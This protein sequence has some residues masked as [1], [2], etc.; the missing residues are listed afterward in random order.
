MGGFALLALQDFPGQGTALV[1]VLD[2]FWNQKG[3]VTPDQFHRFCGPTVPLARLPRRVFTTAETLTADLEIAHFGPA[4]L[5]EATPQVALRDDQGRILWTTSLTS[6]PVPRGELTV[7]GHVEI[8]LVELPRPPDTAWHLALMAPRSRTTGT[9]GSIPRR[10]RSP[11]TVRKSSAPSRSTTP[12]SRSRPASE[13]SGRLLPARFETTPRSPSFSASPAFSGTPPGPTAR[14]PPP[15]ASC[16][17]PPTPAFSS[18][19]TDSHSN[20]QW[21]Y[22]IHQAA[23]LLLDDLPPDL[24][25]IVQ[26]IDDWFTNRRLALVVEAKLGA[27]RLLISSINL[28]EQ[29]DEDPVIRQFR[30]SLLDYAASDRFNPAALSPPSSF[31]AWSNLAP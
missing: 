7:L 16:A 1:G 6:L 22:L 4:D 11:K 8:P 30:A 12:C 25:A 2:P 13:S 3:Y 24:P 23:P 9:S 19:P 18:F 21:W 10:L 28:Q 29:P 15:S 27:G 20:W 26:V 17:N 5:P 31:A 14:R